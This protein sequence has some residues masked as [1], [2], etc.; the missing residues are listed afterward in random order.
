[1]GSVAGFIG[2]LRSSAPVLAAGVTAYDPAVDPT[3][4]AAAGVSA[5]VTA[6]LS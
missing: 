3:G 2:A 4:R 6:L 1:V 5:V